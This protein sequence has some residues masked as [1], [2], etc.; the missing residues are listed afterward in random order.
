MTITLPALADR[1][2]FEGADGSTV[3]ASG[4]TLLDAPAGE[5]LRPRDPGLAS[6]GCW[7]CHVA[8]VSYRLDALQDA[9]LAPGSRL[10]LRPEPANPHDSNAVAV[11]DHSGRLHVGYVPA[12]ICSEV[13]RELRSGSQLE[14][15]VLREYTR[16]EPPQR[17][18]M[19]ILIS[20]LEAV[21]L[22]VQADAKSAN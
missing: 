14:G 9:A 4:F 8:G 22:D 21:A 6:R 1:W 3:T 13:S 20:P 10:S 16:G 5:F 17:V 12:D 15:L 19:S 7:L 2:T 18:G 11:W